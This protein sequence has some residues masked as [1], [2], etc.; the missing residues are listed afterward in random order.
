MGIQMPHCALDVKGNAIVSFPAGI[1]GGEAAA[2]ELA[3]FKLEGD[4]KLIERWT[5]PRIEENGVS[6]E[7]VKLIVALYRFGKKR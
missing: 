1:D 5:E 7:K 3:R 4:V 2:A 6:G